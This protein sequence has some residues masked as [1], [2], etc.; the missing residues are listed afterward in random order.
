MAY[1]NPYQNQHTFH[2]YSKLEE[3]FQMRKAAQMQA[4][5]LQQAQ[6][7]MQMDNSALDRKFKEAQLA[8]IP[9]ENRLKYAELNYKLGQDAI[10]PEGGSPPAINDPLLNSLR[11]VESGG[12]PNALSPKGAAGAFQIMPATAADPGFGVAPLQGWDGKDP[13]TAP[14][15]EQKRFA[16]D[17]LNSQIKRYGDTRLGLAAYNA[18]AGN[19]DKA[20]Q[21]GGGDFNTTMANLPQET[22]NY[23]PKVLSGAGQ[24][25]EARPKFLTKGGKPYTEGLKAG[26]QWAVDEQG[27]RYAAQIPGTSSGGEDGFKNEN[28]LRDEFNTLGKSFRDVQ[29]AYTRMQQATKDPSAAG[30]M[31]AI[32]N[33]MKILDPGSTVREGEFANAQN[34]TGVPGAVL[35][36]YNKILTGER[37]NPEQRAD[38]VKQAG[39]LYQGQKANYQK[40]K[41][42]YTELAKRNKLNPDNVIMDYADAEQPAPAG[43]GTG[44]IAEIEFS[45][46]K[47]QFTPEQ[48]AEYKK[49]KGL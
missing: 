8:Q 46:R 43:V 11:N 25:Q 41:T 35:N 5:Q 15:E 39:N 30:D 31:A 44:K 26:M 32:F 18:G 33:F 9:I 17:Y 10:V 36:M 42:N 40:L 29:D 49:L 34:A 3:E 1:Q 48:I 4:Q 16:N 27:N 24:P 20:K 14:Q 7:A 21:A 47:N 37:L 6:L 38:F 19:V 28:T 13:R 22:Q 23:V 45:L 12:N 2:D